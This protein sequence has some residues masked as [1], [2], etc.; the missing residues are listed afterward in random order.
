MADVM[1]LKAHDR[2]EPVPKK[3]PAR[4]VQREKDDQ[5]VLQELLEDNGAIRNSKQGKSYCSCAPGNKKEFSG[6][7][8]A[9][10]TAL[11]TR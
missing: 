3:T 10:N 9:V 1:P 8:G 6:V 2:I 11:P 4:A 7:C 5:Q